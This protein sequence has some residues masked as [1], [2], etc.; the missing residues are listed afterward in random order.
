VHAHVP[1]EI[2]SSQTPNPDYRWFVFDEKPA[3]ERL[4]V[5]L[6]REPPEGVPIGQALLATGSQAWR[7]PAQLWARLTSTA[8]TT[9][10]SWSE[11]TEGAEWMPSEV[12]AVQSRSALSSDAPAPGMVVSVKD[13][14]AGLVAVIEL[15]HR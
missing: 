13:P 11:R 9:P 1:F 7:P 12:Q 15:K 5:F 10:L 6:V 3:R 4:T 8:P 2:P 14:D